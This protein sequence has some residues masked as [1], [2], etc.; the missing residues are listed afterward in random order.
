MR[1]YYNVVGTTQ[2]ENVLIAPSTLLDSDGEL[3]FIPETWSNEVQ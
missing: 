2:P 3:V 1:Y